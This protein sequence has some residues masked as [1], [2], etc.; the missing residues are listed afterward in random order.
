MPCRELEQRSETLGF[1]RGARH[2]FDPASADLA[3][4][5]EWGSVATPQLFLRERLGKFHDQSV[6]HETDEHL[7]A[8]VSG[9]KTEHATRAE[10]AVMFDEIGEKGLK[11]GSKRTR[12]ATSRL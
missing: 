11:I 10:A 7:P 2:I 12:H 1:S 6:F 5:N 8:G 3:T 4:P 9:G